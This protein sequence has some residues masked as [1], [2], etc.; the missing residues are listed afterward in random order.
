M[1]KNFAVA[2]NSIVTAGLSLML[3]SC[4]GGG[5]SEPSINLCGNGKGV[6][7]VTV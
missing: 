4:G 1:L 5:S 6:C 2:R 3:I 7:A